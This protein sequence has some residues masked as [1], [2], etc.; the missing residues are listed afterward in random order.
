MAEEWVRWRGRW[1]T[2][3]A[4]PKKP[5]RSE[6]RPWELLGGLPSSAGPGDDGFRC[7][8]AVRSRCSTPPITA[9]CRPVGLT[10]KPS[11]AV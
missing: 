11:T 2:A 5:A 1:A 10:C 8:L 7:Y 9:A 3:L 6:R 4:V